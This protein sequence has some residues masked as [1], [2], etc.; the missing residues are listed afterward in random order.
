MQQELATGTSTLF[1]QVQQQIFRKM[2]LARLIPK[3]E[4]ELKAAGVSM[5]GY[6]ERFGGYKGK[7]D[8]ELM[9]WML[10]HC[11]DAAASGDAHKFKEYLAITTACLEQASM[12]GNWQIAY[13]LSLLEEPPSQVF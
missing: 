8:Q 10:V 13:V 1:L 12:D 3:T 4:Q 2:Y 6:L 9:I 11:M 7:H 5:T